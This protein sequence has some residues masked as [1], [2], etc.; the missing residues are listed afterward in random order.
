[1]LTE[2]YGVDALKISIVLE[3]HKRFKVTKR[4]VH[5]A[6]PSE[7]DTYLFFNHKSTVPLEFGEQGRTVNQHYLEILVRIH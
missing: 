4:G 7:D 5:V 1:M 3:R 2:I 6:G